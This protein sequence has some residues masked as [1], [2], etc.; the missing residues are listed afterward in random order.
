MFGPTNKIMH[1][2]SHSNIADNE[3]ILKLKSFGLEELS[4]SLGFWQRKS[5][6][7]SCCSLIMGCLSSLLSGQG[8]YSSWADR[9]G[10]LTNQ[11]ISKQAVSDRVNGSFCAVLQALV[12]R[13]IHAQNNACALEL[14]GQ[15]E[16]VVLEDSTV[17]SLPER[18]HKFFPGN[19]SRGKRKAAAKLQVAINIT[20][21]HVNH[22][23]L[24]DFCENDQSA[25][26]QIIE[27][28]TPGTL[29]IRDLGYFVLGAM[30]EMQDKSI[31]FITRYKHQA[32]LYNPQTNQQIDLVKLLQNRSELKGKVRVGKRQAMEM[33][34]VAVRLPKKVA[35][36]KRRKMK[37]NR[38]KRLNPSKQRLKLAEWNIFLTSVE[39]EKI[40]VQDLVE[41]YRI[42]WHIE[43]VFKSWKS[44]F[45]LHSL[46]PKQAVRPFQ[47]KAIILLLM[48]Y[49]IMIQLPLY[50]GTLGAKRCKVSLMKLSAFLRNFHVMDLP[51]T[52]QKRYPYYTKV[53]QHGKRKR[54]SMAHRILT[55]A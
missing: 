17:L 12:G 28:L 50:F 11:T 44:V 14:C 38:D 4:K 13:A 46:L 16:N 5:G 40:Q 6:K 51:E 34:L 36:E 54:E 49:A 25:A 19:Y 18:L 21:G 23:H 22:V 1:A 7:I 3:L 27:Q 32:H 37:Q 15:Y 20:K 52:T 41:L 26:Y 31:D 43:M 55:L 10:F 53:T 42:R 24:T 29:V 39:P 48:L 45:K 47:V 9:I 35:D 2:N 33:T 30:A 8:S